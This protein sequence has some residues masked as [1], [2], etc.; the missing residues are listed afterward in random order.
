M[1]SI[2]FPMWQENRKILL[3]KILELVPQNSWR[4][5]VFQF[6][7]IGP[8]PLGQDM[9]DF[10]NKAEQDKWGIEISFKKL[11]DTALSL[12]DL[13]ECMIVA[14]CGDNIKEIEYPNIINDKM[15]D[16][17]IV[18]EDS[19]SWII[20]GRDEIVERFDAYLNR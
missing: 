19:T 10:A 8:G 17:Y 18:A 12:E 1:R 3:G 4:W 20:S 6:D 16:L 2:E 7:A 15:Y 13:N 5:V 14:V 11:M 9:A